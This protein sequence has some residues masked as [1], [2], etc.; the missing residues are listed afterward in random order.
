MEINQTKVVPVIA[1]ELR[2]YIKV[3]DQFC[4]S[5]HDD[6][7]NDLGGQADGYVPG[8]MP[9][10]HYGDYL[11][12]NIDL[13]T[14]LITNWEKPTREEVEAFIAQDESE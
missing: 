3:R 2:I 4:A 7:G 9:G 5:I 12:L 6:A 14:G 10:Q 8:F 11:I 1:K 13:D